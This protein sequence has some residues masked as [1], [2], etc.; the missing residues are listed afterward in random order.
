MEVAREEL[1]E[2]RVKPI[3][4]GPVDGNIF[5]VMGAASKALKKVGMY[6]ESEEMC[7]K[8][9]NAHSYDEAL[10]IC[11]AYVEFNL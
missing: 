9:F 3:V 5:G 11:M 10:Q 2:D 4:S 7:N 6:K 8:V 1:I